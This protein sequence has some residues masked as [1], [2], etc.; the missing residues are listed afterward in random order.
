MTINNIDLS[1]ERLKE[2]CL[3]YQVKEL[4]IFG[5]ALRDDFN[6]GSDIDLLV[7]FYDNTGYSLFEIVRIKEE[8]EQFLNRPVDL[9]NRKAIG[10]SKNRYRKRAILESAK[11]I[12]PAS[13]L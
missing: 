4:S 9:V 2:I 3:K 6:S 8:F 13:F 10:K 7:T 1:E 5:S 11:V 12:Y